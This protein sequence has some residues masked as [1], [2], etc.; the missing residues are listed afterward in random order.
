MKRSKWIRFLALTLLLAMAVGAIPAAMATEE[1]AVEQTV[2]DGVSDESLE[3]E[4]EVTASVSPEPEPMPSKQPPA[5]EEA[6]EKTK[7]SAEDQEPTDMNG[8]TL[9]RHAVSTGGPRRARAASYGTVGKSTC[10]DFAGY[11]SPY[12]YCNRYATQGTHVYGHYYY[13]STIAYHTVDGDWAYCIEP[14]TSSVGGQT[15]YSYDGNSAASDSYWMLELDSWQRYYI[16]QIMAFGYPSIDRGYSVQAQYAATQTLIWEV[17]SKCRYNDG[18]MYSSDYG[19]YSKI[20]AVLGSPYQACYDGILSS[21]SSGISDGTIPS[22]ASSSSSDPKAVT[23]TYNS[24]TNCYEGSAYDSTLKTMSYYTFSYPGVSITRRGNFIDISVPASSAASV[25]GKTIT[26][27]SSQKN[28]N[29]SNPA[30]WENSTYQT[31]LSSGSAEYMK[32]YIKL[33]WPEPEPEP[34][35]GALKI[36][37]KVSDSGI[38]LSGWKFDISISGIGTITRTTNSSGVINVT[39]IPAGSKCTVTES[40]Y[41]GYK[42]LSSQSVTVYEGSSSTVTFTN[43]PLKGNLTVNKSVN[44][45]TKAGFKFRLYGTSTIGKSVD[46]TATTNSSGKATFSN[47]YVGTYTLEEVDPGN[48]YI[49]PSSKTVTISANATTGAAYTTTASMTNTWKYWRASVTKVDAETGTPQG[50]ASLEGAEYTLYKSGTAVKT[51]TVKNGSFVTDLYPCTDSDSV[52]TLKETKAPPGYALDETVYKLTTGYSHYSN[53]ENAFNVTVSDQVIQGTIQLDKRAVN[54]VSGVK[55]PEQ[56]AT[57]QVWLK[58]AGS[59][60]KAKAAERDVIIIGEDGKGASKNLPYGVYCIRQISGWEGY[61]MDETIYEAAIT[62]QGETVTKDVN[63]DDLAIENNIW[64]GTL[65]ILKVDGDTREPLAGAEFTLTGSD[66]SKVTLETDS[67]GKAEFSDLVYG[68]DYTW[69]ETK[70][71]K[72]YLLDEANTGTWSVTKHDDSVEIT[73]EDYRRPGSITVTKQNA[74]SEPLPGAVFLLEYWDGSAWKPVTGR[75]NDVVTIGACTSEGLTDG[76]LTTDESGKVIF[77]GL[78]ADDQL[79]YR[80]T[81]VKAPEGYELLAEPVFEG[82]LPV[83]YNAEKVSAEPEEIIG[84]TAYFY[85]PTFTVTNGHVYEMPMTGGRNLP[86]TP[87]GAV[88]ILLSTFPIILYFTKR[89]TIA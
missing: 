15:Y 80:L 21:I 32:A 56:G 19:L 44:Y 81:E 59:Y 29:T 33:T 58:S 10:V 45:G 14:N 25:K 73:C 16:Q 5:A 71:P 34:E 46:V 54:T 2:P 41:G 17:V 4:P 88:M 64:L 69:T 48:A 20:Y 22:F 87:I 35:D 77:E 67:A 12:W 62:T 27:I 37:K 83:S 76:Q 85:N 68:V 84:G 3:V 51:Y 49:K 53:A 89:R 75:S 18:I 43:Q 28:M 6:Q 66:G 9:T 11:T 57:F 70:A 60:E 72:G 30:I 13:C 79:Q 38:G 47:I 61:D 82:V 31:V 7:E 24:S 26:G 63:K 23:L 39:G 78:W 86:L 74:D 36:V 55:Q 42:V 8:E 52:Y 65:S 50:D 1:S 40:S